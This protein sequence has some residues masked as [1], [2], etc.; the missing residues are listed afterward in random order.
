MFS[1]FRVY[2]LG[3]Q[4][5][6]QGA[7][8]IEQFSVGCQKRLAQGASLQLKQKQT[9]HHEVNHDLMLAHRG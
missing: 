2:R 4:P 3:E 1:R 6:R 5:D 7:K 9:F 8:E